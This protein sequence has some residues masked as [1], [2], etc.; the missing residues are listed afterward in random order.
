MEGKEMRPCWHC[1]RKHMDSLYPTNRAPAQITFTTTM[2]PSKGAGK[3]AQGK[4]KGKGKLVSVVNPYYYDGY[5]YKC[6]RWGHRSTTC[7]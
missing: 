6:G 5:C 2:D 3:G 4:S 1:G 7:K